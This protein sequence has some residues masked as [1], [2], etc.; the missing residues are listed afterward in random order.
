MLFHIIV[1]PPWRLLVSRNLDPCSS[2][3]NTCGTMHR[4]AAPRRPVSRDGN[5]SSSTLLWTMVAPPGITWWDPCSSNLLW[6]MVAPP[7]IMWWDPCSSTLLWTMVVPPGITWW[8]PCS[9]NL[10]W[11]MVAPPGI[12]WWD[13]CSSTLLWTMVAPPGITWWDPCSSTL[14]WDHRGAAWYHVMGSMLFHVTVGPSWRRLVSRDVNPCSS[15]LLWDNPG[16]AWYHVMWIH[17]LPHYDCGT[18]VARHGN[19]T[20]APFTM[21]GAQSIIV[22]FTTD[23]WYPESECGGRR[24]ITE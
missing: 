24:H 7:G 1:A 18:I 10:L 13:P 23:R 8:D 5:P 9:S 16:A 4:G 22:Q 14:L 20:V 17:A 21:T 19:V 11:T 15:T 12:M 2:M 6:T 3:F